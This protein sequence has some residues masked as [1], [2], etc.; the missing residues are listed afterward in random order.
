MSGEAARFALV[1]TAG[2]AVNVAAFTGLYALG[3]R[4]GVAAVTAYLLSNALMYLGNR[5]F[6]F[7]PGRAGF[8]SGYLRFLLVGLLVVTLMVALLTGLVE[9][10][11][12]DPRLAQALAL[13]LLTPLAFALNR[14]W[15]FSAAPTSPRPSLREI[16]GRRERDEPGVPGRA[17]GG[18]PVLPELPTA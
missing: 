3:A 11:G 7:G 13:C 2:Y 17:S 10:L 6:T 12:S 18:R 9:A 14:R 1:G 5:R 4:Y 16:P 8:W 15:T